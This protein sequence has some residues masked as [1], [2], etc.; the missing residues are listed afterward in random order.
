[1]DQCCDIAL[2]SRLRNLTKLEIK[3]RNL[4]DLHFLKNLTKLEYLVLQA[5]NLD[6]IEFVQNISNLLSPINIAIN[7]VE[8]IRPLKRG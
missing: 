7:R 5:C 8:D 4:S 6:N 1:M 2:V 3:H